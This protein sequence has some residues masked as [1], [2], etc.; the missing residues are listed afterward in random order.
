MHA[1]RS[2]RDRLASLAKGFSGRNIKEV[3]EQA[4]RACAARIVRGDA[5]KGSL[6]QWKDYADAVKARLASGLQ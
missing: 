5:A 2:D 6:P 4:E 1:C 3:C